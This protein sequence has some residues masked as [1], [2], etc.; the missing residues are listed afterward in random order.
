MAKILIAG[1]AVVIRSGLQLADIKKLEKYSPKSLYLY[2]EDEET[3]KK[4]PV[5]RVGTT[6]GNGSA[7]SSAVFFG[8]ACH[9]E[10]GLATITTQLPEGVTSVRDWVADEYGLAVVRLNKIEAGFEASLTAVD[11]AKAEMEANIEIL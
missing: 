2:E 5:F 10:D 4:F 3:G 6:K 9:S 8:S 1:N 11:E 7:S